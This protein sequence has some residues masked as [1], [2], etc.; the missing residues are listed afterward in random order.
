MLTKTRMALL[1]TPSLAAIIA[2]GVAC[3]GCG[4]KASDDKGGGDKADKAGD[5]A[6]DKAA[7]A[8]PAK[9]AFKKLGSL[10]LE[11]EVPDDANIEDTSKGAGYPSVAVYAS[12]TT[13]VSGTGDMSDVKPTIEETK[14]QLGKD[15]NKLK[16]F[17]KED[18]T[19]DGW[20]LELTRDSMVEPGKELYGVSVRRNIGGAAWDCGTNAASKDEQAKAEKLCLS[21]RAAK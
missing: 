11:A 19:A 21:L 18:K 12:P 16:T 1:L 13:F 10:P 2:S 8:P 6:G 15:P 20:V 5:K 7:A 4:K 14:A 9:L 17:T 3:F